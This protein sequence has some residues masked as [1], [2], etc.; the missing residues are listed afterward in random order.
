MAS[1]PDYVVVAFLLVGL[2]RKR[3][4]ET[5]FVAECCELYEHTDNTKPLV[6]DLMRQS[7]MQYYGA[8]YQEAQR[9]SRLPG[10]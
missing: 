8:L 5:L 1:V 2:K 3:E 9:R 10:Q 7:R 6:V 4:S